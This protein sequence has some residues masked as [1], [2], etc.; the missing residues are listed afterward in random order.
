M[1]AEYCRLWRDRLSVSETTQ[2][3]IGEQRS[4]SSLRMTLPTGSTTTSSTTVPTSRVGVVAPYCG[5]PLHVDNIDDV[6]GAIQFPS[7]TGEES[8]SIFWEQGG[9]SYTL[10][11]GAMRGA[12]RADLNIYPVQKLLTCKDPKQRSRSA[13]TRMKVWMDSTTPRG[14]L[15]QQIVREFQ[16]TVVEELRCQ[17][18]CQSGRAWST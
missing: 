13:T 16:Q 5:A 1:I 14:Q 8:S 15:M 4:T 6:I 3:D 2:E 12:F 7:Q 10:K 17:S 18:G 11:S 9:Y